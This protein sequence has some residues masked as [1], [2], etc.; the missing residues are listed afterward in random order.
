MVNYFMRFPK[1]KYKAVTFSYDDGCREDLK[2][3]EEINKYGIKCTFNINSK[4]VGNTEAG[5][6]TR[7]EIAEHIIGT[8]H[9]IAV[10]GARHK[11]PG[12]AD[13][14]DGIKDVLDGR[15]ELERMF[16]GI[17]KGMAYP[18]SGVTRFDNGAE[19]KDV[20]RYLTYL[21]IVYARTLGGDNNGFYMPED[22]HSWMPTAHHNNAMNYIDEFLNLN[23]GEM[24]AG[25]RRPRLFYM[26]GHAYEFERDD[27]WS[28]LTDV[29]E[30]ISGKQDIWYATNMEIYNYTMAYRALEFNVDRTVVFNPTLYT[31]WFEAD[32]KSYCIKS[33][34]TLNI[35]E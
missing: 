14:T 30:K 3:V 33:G 23:V 22:W 29:C 19:Y 2:L 21:G 5:K 10:H 13:L 26:W 20:K 31:V 16:G 34:E 11:A 6:L 18:N 9:E 4:W 35:A 7:D 25:A 32:G 27:N 8:G 28:L 17:I 12:M 24:Y 15:N 1:G